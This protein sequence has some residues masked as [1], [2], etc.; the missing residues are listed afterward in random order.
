VRNETSLWSPNIQYCEPFRDYQNA[1]VNSETYLQSILCGVFKT[2]R[3]REPITCIHVNF[4]VGSPYRSINLY[5]YMGTKPY[6]VLS[7]I[8]ARV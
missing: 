5:V 7:L 6:K 3:V 2:S 8:L 4:G 1:L